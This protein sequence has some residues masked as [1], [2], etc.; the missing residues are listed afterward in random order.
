[1][2]THDMSSLSGLF[3]S[4]LS[5][6][7]LALPLLGLVLDATA[8]AAALKQLYHKRVNELAYKK[9]PWFGMVPKNEE[10]GGANKAIAM[11]I[12]HVAGVSALF[13]NAQTN[14]R[15]STYSRFTLT[16]AKR[17]ALCSVDSETVLASQGDNFALLEAVKAEM[18]SAIHGAS[19]AIAIDMFKNGGGARGQVSTGS[20]V[21]STTITLADI[22]AITNFEVGMTVQA[23][24]DDGTG[25]AGV[26]SGSAV[27]TGVDRDL[28]TLTVSGNWNAAGNI[29][30]IATS[31]FLFLSGDYNAAVAG[32]EAWCPAS[33]PGAT[34][35]FGL[36]RTADV[37]RLGGIRFDASTFA[38]EEGLIKALGRAG[39]EG[40]SIDTGFMNYVDWTALVNALGSKAVRP[41]DTNSMATSSDGNFGYETLVLHGPTG[42]VKIVPDQNCVQGVC[43]LLQLDT[44]TLHSIG[45]APRILDEDGTKMLREAAADAYEI[46][47]GFY[48]N[49]ACDAPG[50]NVRVKLQ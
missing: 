8:F 47:V 12:A 38:I 23:S 33:A 46:R 31:D 27:L 45:S 9:N 44:W 4:L 15:P 37:T 5:M 6:V 25:G 18:D 36:N 22:N 28:G 19:R 41:A 30:N 11:R 35:F 10:F 42:P 1:M 49:L 40:A 29:P 17:Y 16:R 7:G 50:W 24:V 21:G 20:T 13:T 43:W 39:R 2:H 34:L 48:G 3:L 26:R 32:L 14:K